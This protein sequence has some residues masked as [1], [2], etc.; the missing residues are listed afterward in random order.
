MAEKWII[1]TSDGEEYNLKTEQDLSEIPEQ[2]D[3]HILK[4]ATGHHGF[5]VTYNADSIPGIAGK[6]LR[7]MQREIRT[8][9]MPIRIGGKDPEDFHRHFSKLR[10]SLNPEQEH[11][12]WVTNQEGQTKIIYVRYRSGFDAVVDDWTRALN[13]TKVGLYFDAFDPYFYD[14]PGSELTRNYSPTPW[15]T[16]F[17]TYT[18]V[19]AFTADSLAGDKR[20]TI[21]DTSNCT[22]GKEIEIRG[23]D[24]VVGA[25]LDIAEA[26]EEE[27]TEAMPTMLYMTVDNANPQKHQLFNLQGWLRDLF[28]NL[29]IPNK[30]VKIVRTWT[31]AEYLSTNPTLTQTC[32]GTQTNTYTGSGSVTQTNTCTQIAFTDDKGVFKLTD[33]LDWEG[34]YT[35]TATFPGDHNHAVSD[36]VITTIKCGTESTTSLTLSSTVGHPLKNASFN[37]YGRLSVG[38]TNLQSKLIMLY[39][40]TPSGYTELGRTMTDSTGRYSFALSES[41][42]GWKSYKVTY[43]GDAIPEDTRR[44]LSGWMDWLFDSLFGWIEGRHSPG[45]Y[46]SA[47][48]KLNVEIGNVSYAINYHVALTP[49]QIN[50]GEIQYFGANKFNAVVCIAEKVDDN[51]ST[52]LAIIE[53]QGLMPIIDISVITDKDVS[54]TSHATWINS[55]Y[56]AGWRYIAGFNSTGRASPNDPTYIHSLHSGFKYINYNAAPHT[57]TTTNS[58]ISGTGVYQNSFECMTAA[59]IPY[60]KS[61]T[62]SAYGASPSVK[63][64][65]FAP[66]LD[67]TKINAMLPKSVANASP[68][69]CDLLH[70]S[71]ENAVGMSNFLVWFHPKY[72]AVTARDVTEEKISLYKSLGFDDLIETMRETYPPLLTEDGHTY[73]WAEPTAKAVSLT[74]T[75]ISDPLTFS[76]ILSLFKDGTAI[77]NATIKLEEFTGTWGVIDTTTTDDDGIY[78]FEVTATAGEHYYRVHYEGDGTH[79]AFIAPDTDGIKILH[80]VSYIP[81]SVFETNTIASIDSPT[82]LTLTNPLANDF[83]ISGEAYIVEVDTAD[84][85]LTPD[86]AVRVVNNSVDLLVFWMRGCPPCYALK[87]QV[88]AIVQRYSNV[89]ATYCEIHDHDSGTIDE[90]GHVNIGMDEAALRYPLGY[91]LAQTCGPQLP[92]AYGVI[93]T[94]MPAVLCVYR[95]GL[96][97]K[98]WCGVHT[99]GT[100]PVSTE[101]ILDTCGPRM[102]WRLGGESALGYRDIINNKG[103]TTAYPVWTIT[104]P[105]KV[106]VIR[107]ITTGESFSINYDLIA[108]EAV[109][110]DANMNAHTCASTHSASYM[111]SGYMKSDI[112]PTCQGKGVI[113]ASC[114]NCG[115]GQICPTCNGSGTVSVWVPASSGTTRDMGGMYNLRYAI[116]QTQRT[117]W[118]F[119]PGTNVIEIEMGATE[120]YKSMVNLNLVQGY[121]GI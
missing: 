23:V 112:C 10:R 92:P 113:P 120:Y 60:I 9:Y 34:E 56:T 12:L 40:S 84:S 103:D 98:H 83:T 37:L 47:E 81:Q 28:T 99:T 108:G 86:D 77:A 94:I 52:E 25:E 74:V 117:F 8:I 97:I 49:N 33:I 20:I 45:R 102:T 115:G 114:V 88:N 35:Y 61:F 2:S 64:G 78:S 17:F 68:T 41:A 42:E 16:N 119:E 111:S 39:K 100:D 31:P 91:N 85:F 5:P 70:W 6:E 72:N 43:A 11:Q 54:L 75:Y 118:G 59:A 29:H 116:D 46:S 90:M 58:D 57:G 26:E 63:S 101:E 15:A 95:D 51:Y 38:D 19:Q 66:V 106:P 3:Y 121:E 76:G 21:E 104:G 79:M 7:D 22:V 105:G 30:L 18:V 27:S 36:S 65:L 107:N 14:P 71:Y 44:R 1:K 48:T 110:I 4:G 53:A 87:A 55:L 109:V 50:N 67:N 80:L 13:W 96:F 24:L 89:T 69:Y 73:T 62:A 32:S 82:V 93:G